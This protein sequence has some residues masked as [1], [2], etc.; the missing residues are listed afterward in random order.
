M[1]QRKCAVRKNKNGKNSSQDFYGKTILK[2]INYYIYVLLGLS[3]GVTIATQAGVNATLRGALQSP[4]QAALISFAVGTALLS[5]IVLSQAS[6]SSGTIFQTNKWLSI[7]GL[8]SLPW[9]AWIG[10]ALGA[11][12]VTLSVFLAPRLGALLLAVSVITGQI[13]ASLFFDKYGL[14]GYPQLDIGAKRLIGATLM[15]LGLFLVA[16]K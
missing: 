5:L 9:W 14:I 2:D 1:V 3:V 4:M 6:L 7:E 16:S 13:V 15:L 12:N 8:A 10:G 11:F